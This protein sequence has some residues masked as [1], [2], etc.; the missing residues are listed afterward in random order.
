LKGKLVEHHA[1]SPVSQVF[2]NCLL[3]Y[4]LWIAF[5]KSFDAMISIDASFVAL[6][7][8]CAGEFDKNF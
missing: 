5:T 6:P 3:L 2:D 4:Y 7:P 1:Q 8:S